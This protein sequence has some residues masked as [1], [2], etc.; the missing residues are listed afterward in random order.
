MSG[1]HE[2]ISR[3][4]RQAAGAV[5][6]RGLH[7]HQ[8]CLCHHPCHADRSGRAIDLG[9]HLLW[10][11]RAWR[12]RADAHIAARALRSRRLS[13]R[14]ISGVLEAD[15]A[16]RFRTVDV[17]VSDPGLDPDRPR[18][19]LDHR[20]SGGLDHHRLGAR[21]PAGRACRLLPEKP[22]T[23]ADGRDRHGAAPDS[24][25][26]PGAAAADR[27]RLSVAGAADHRRFGDEPAADL[28]L[29]LLSPA[30]CSTRSCR[31]SR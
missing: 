17:G 14:A 22:R 24:L 13:D 23:E 9:G 8:P 15:P 27:V 21:K 6:A 5:R 31:R 16:R 12:D 2:R 18:A 30:S 28:D 3:L 19:A 1:A 20:T 26:H 25:L 29:G 10:Q 11:H 4:H 7:R